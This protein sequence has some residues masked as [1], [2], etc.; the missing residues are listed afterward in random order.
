MT[1][2]KIGRLLVR[3][4]FR[5]DLPT[6]LLDGQIAFAVDT[7]ELF[8]G[9][10]N[11][12]NATVSDARGD[13]NIRLITEVDPFAQPNTFVSINLDPGP[14]TVLIFSTGDDFLIL[15]Y[16]LAYRDVGPYFSGSLKIY[17]TSI[18]HAPASDNSV[19]FAIQKVGT[20][21]TLTANNNTSTREINLT[22]QFRAWSDGLN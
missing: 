20:I 9:A 7:G 17:D 2:Q 15:D 6:D 1:I 16:G 13:G 21:R 12:S 11:A 10:P 8:V 14:N 22:Y 19:T 5:D 4:G 18:N 3:R